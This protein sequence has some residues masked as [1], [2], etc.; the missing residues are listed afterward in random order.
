MDAEYAEVGEAVEAAA[1][2]VLRSGSYVLGPETLAFEQEMARL[3]GVAS[4]VGVGSGTEALVLAL[5]ALGVGPGD[6]VVVP[7]F[8]F[9]ATVEAVLAVGA[10]PV[11]ADV[12]EGGFHLNPQTVAEALTP[13]TRA[14]VPVHLFG[15][16]ADMAALLE[17]C[18]P[19]DVALVEDAAQAIGAAR[20]GRAAGAWGAAG[21]FSFYPSKNL[22]AAGDGGCITAQD[23]DLVEQMRLLRSHGGRGDA[24]V[25]VGTSSRLDSIQAAVLRVKLPFLKAWNETRARNA[26]IYAVELAGCSGVRLPEA[27]SEEILVW[28]Q[29]TL[30]CDDPGAM[31]SVL[32]EAGI[33]T[34]HYY[35][36]PVC[37][38]AALGEL[39][40]PAGDFPHAHRAC[41][42]SFS[43]P[44]RPS[45]TPD[46]IREI[47]GVIRGAL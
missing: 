31:R 22:G 8:T 18:E 20:G 26:R 6:D 34:R 23:P 42:E 37:E 40:R 38:E 19:L 45:C 5:R 15:R 32:E 27:P 33:E 43:V 7:A 13:A 1:L 21:C 30:R 10:R 9:F 41:R 29:Y 35:A 11:F 17:L 16:C 4:A 24:H 46:E 14:V 44:V 25:R 47:A 39:R 36:R 3:V 2:R 28:S 12:E